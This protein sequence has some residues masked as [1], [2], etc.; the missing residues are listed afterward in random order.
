MSLALRHQP[1]VLGLTLDEHGWTS[2]EAL[3]KGM[4]FKGHKIS[5]TELEEVVENNNKKRF[6]FSEDKLLIRAS[7][8]HSIEIDLELEEVE[9]P[10]ILYHGTAIINVASIRKNGIEKRARHHVHLSGDKDTAL[11]VGI[12]HGKPE[13]LN[14]L[15]GKMYQDGFKFYRSANGVWLTD[16]VPGKYIE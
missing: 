15:A 10:E 6:A 8:G 5:M 2:V 14:I 12:R 9:P 13:I 4:A 1:D 16:F 7:Q 3:L 11:K